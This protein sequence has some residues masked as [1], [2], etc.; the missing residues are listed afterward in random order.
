MKTKKRT[1][2]TYPYTQKTP[3]GKVK[4]YKNTISGKPLFV[5]TW[6]TEEGRQRKSYTSEIEAHQRA[7]EILD[8]LKNG[9]LL[10]R[11]ISSEKAALI[12]EYEKLLGEHG[13]TLGE[14]VRFYL[15]N[16]VKQVGSDVLTWDAVQEYLKNQFEDQTTRHYATAKSILQKFGRALNRPLNKITVKDLDGYFKKL[17]QNGRTRNNHLG[18]VRTFM[19]WA[20]GW[21]GYLPQGD[22][23]IDKIKKYDVKGVV[24][25]LFTPEEMEKLL[26]EADESIKPYLAIGAFA[27]VRS[28]ETLRLTWEDI[29]LEEKVIKLNADI[30][31]TSRRRLAVM[32]DNLVAWLREY[33][34]DKKGS[35]T[36][37]FEKYYYWRRKLTR[38]L[39]LPWKSNALRKGY[40]SYRMAQPDAEA[41]LVAKQCGNSPDMVEEHY[42]GLV[43]PSESTKWFS[44][45]P[46][47]IVVASTIILH[48]WYCTG[49][50]P[51][52]P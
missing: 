11:S 20:Q 4:I 37:P 8:D 12:S 23:E 21:G 41:A 44:I 18:Y 17:S 22:L 47:K 3:F 31:K 34:G 38:D 35:V 33:K 32:P 43:S 15:A 10:R 51:T 27:G 13:A 24:P 30:T 26:N 36:P 1:E 7:E 5:V 46:K 39:S 6:V 50:T 19:K 29:D 52:L 45:V 48:Y 16:K 9:A 25:D 49:L 14:A 42:K 2:I 28:A 40:I